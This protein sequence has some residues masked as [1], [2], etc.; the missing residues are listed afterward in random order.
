M[1]VSTFQEPGTLTEGQSFLQKI[2]SQAQFHNAKHT[3]FNGRCTFITLI[4]MTCISRG[5]LIFIVAVPC[6]HG[7]QRVLGALYAITLLVSSYSTLSDHL[8]L[9]SYCINFLGIVRTKP[10]GHR[11]YRVHPKSFPYPKRRAQI[12]YARAN[13]LSLSLCFMLPCL[14]WQPLGHF[15]FLSLLCSR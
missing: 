6:R 9:L 5:A 13:C 11:C 8:I 1:L 4:R 14:S 10:R 7:Y 15:S 2:I 3:S 12:K